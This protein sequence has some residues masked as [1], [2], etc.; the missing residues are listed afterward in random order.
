MQDNPARPVHRFVQPC[1][2]TQRRDP[3]WHLML[4]AN[5]YVP[6]KPC[7][8]PVHNLVNRIRC[9]RRIGV[10]LIVTIQLFLDARQPSI[11]L[12][13]FAFGFAGVQRGKAADDA[14]LTLGDD[15][16]GVGYDEK[17]AAYKR[18]AQIIEKSG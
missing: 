7:V 14:R 12:D 13:R 2:G 8:G 18:N 16:V 3:Q 1:L 5:F 9:S 10:C 11:K 4:D 17:W 15:Q 6:L